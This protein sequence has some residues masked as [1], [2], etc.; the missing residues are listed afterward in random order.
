[1]ADRRFQ[2]LPYKT[3]KAGKRGQTEGRPP[4]QPD[5]RQWDLQMTG[6]QIKTRDRLLPE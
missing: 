3:C 5:L 6:G 2:I 4:E 1:M